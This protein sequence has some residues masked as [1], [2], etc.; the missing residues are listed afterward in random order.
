MSRSRGRICGPRSDAGDWDTARRVHE[1]HL[2][3]FRANFLTS[4]PVPVKAAMAEMGLIHDVLRPPLLPLDDANRTRL[5]AV[6]AGVGLLP[7]REE[8]A[9]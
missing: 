8:A 2:E 6:L 3:L 7:G 5:R 4:N 1:R 9:A